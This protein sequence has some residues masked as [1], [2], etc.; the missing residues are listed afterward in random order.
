MSK[1]FNPS[2]YHNINNHITKVTINYNIQIMLIT[3]SLIIT[4]MQQMFRSNK[5]IYL[6]V[7]A[8]C[9]INISY[10]FINSILWKPSIIYDIS[11]F[12][13]DPQI[14]TDHI[15]QLYGILK[16][17][18]L[19]YDPS[20]NCYRFVL[21]NFKNDISVIFKGIASV[22]LKEGDN[23][24]ITGYLPNVENKCKVVA[25]KYNTNHSMEVENWDNTISKQRDNNSITI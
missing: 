20:S 11:D 15:F 3:R 5:K 18:S 10:I 2:K 19:E 4:K 25:T 9:G 23:V 21:T 14:T 17:N 12:L 13:G 16:Q 1:T 24:I 22:E 7:L 6:S 8:L